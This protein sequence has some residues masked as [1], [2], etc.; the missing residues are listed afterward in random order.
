VIPGRGSS[1]IG[2]T[3]KAELTRDELTGILTDGFFPPCR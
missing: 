3:I 2:G 1:L